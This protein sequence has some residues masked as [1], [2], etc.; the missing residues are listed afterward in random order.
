MKNSF[1]LAADD[2]GSAVKMFR[3][4][5]G[6]AWNDLKQRYRRTILG[7]F[8]ISLSIGVTITGLGFLFGVI[9][10]QK[11]SIYIPYLAA[12]MMFWAFV[13]GILTEGA[14]SFVTMSNV[15]KQ[16]KIP[17][18]LCVLRV[19]YRHAL[20]LIHNLIVAAVIF[21]FF[22][23]DLMAFNPAVFFQLFLC[24]VILF[25]LSLFLAIISARYRDI[26]PILT[27]G[28]Q[29]IFY[30]TPIIWSEEQITSSPTL[31]MVLKYNPFYYVLDALRNTLYGLSVTEFH[32]QVLGAM[33][34]GSMVLGY[35]MLAINY[36][37]IAFW[38]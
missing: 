34:L 35:T 6:L 29:L 19:I 23:I 33:A 1:E 5:H 12:G 21:L 27:N 11:T 18:S 22:K 4:I 25:G 32:L 36:K 13:A 2:I 20:L 8:W 28:L 17:F 14:D 10:S 26:H 37:R 16:I 9:F 7:P 15:L 31:Q 3:L 38:L 24:L 30:I